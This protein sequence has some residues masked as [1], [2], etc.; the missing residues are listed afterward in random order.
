[1]YSTPPLKPGRFVAEAVRV[2]RAGGHVAVYGKRWPPRPQGTRLVRRI[3][4]LTRCQHAPRVCFV[5][6][7]LSPALTLEAAA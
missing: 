2:T 6:E 1:M 4:V 7:K 5:F 3:V